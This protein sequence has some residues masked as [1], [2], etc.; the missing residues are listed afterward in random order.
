[1]FTGIVQYRGIV[2]TTEKV[3][4]GMKF[5]INANNWS[6]KPKHGESICVNGVC[7]T[8]TSD[9]GLFTFD[10]IS[11]T[12][13]CTTF[14][15][16]K[17]GD[18]VNLE[19]CVK[20]AS[21]MSGHIVQ[22]HVDGVGTVENRYDGIEEVRLTIRP[23]KNLLDFIVPKGSIT[24]DGVSMTLAEVHK[25]TFELA[26]IPTTIDLTTLG[27]VQIGSKVNLEADIITKTIAH[28]MRRM[29]SND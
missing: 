21:L 17:V 8:C 23:P 7:L 11:Q 29:Q 26:L 5:K 12:L 9:I 16:L 2:E 19:T 14:G 4:F 1:M 13:A 10:V 27:L 6:H 28:I 22:G 25:D 18:P 15:D 24:A 20:P 3:D